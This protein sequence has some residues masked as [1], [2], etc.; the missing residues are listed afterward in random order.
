MFYSLRFVFIHPTLRNFKEYLGSLHRPYQPREKL[1]YS[2]SLRGRHVG[3]DWV[4]HRH[5]EM[6]LRSGSK[7]L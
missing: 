2:S 1:A 4:G 5:D 6:R 7:L 3:L